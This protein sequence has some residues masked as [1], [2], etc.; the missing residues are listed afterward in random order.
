MMDVSKCPKCGSGDIEAGFDEEVNLVEGTIITYCYCMDC[1]C[2][3][4]IHWGSVA[5]CNIANR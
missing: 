3:W 2:E 1:L 4:E 5:V